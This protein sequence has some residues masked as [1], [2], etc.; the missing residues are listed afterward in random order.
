LYERKTDHSS[1]IIK[2]YDEL[3]AKGDH[4]EKSKPILFSL[5]LDRSKRATRSSP[6]V[7]LGL[8]LKV[9]ST[10]FK[11]IDGGWFNLDKRIANHVW[12]LNNLNL[13]LNP[14]AANDQDKV[15]Y[16]W[17]NDA[18]DDSRGKQAKMDDQGLYIPVSNKLGF[19]AKLRFTLESR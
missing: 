10:D 13:L 6:T 11:I 14:E 16:S 12:F 4:T 7:R 1:A 5:F 17:V 19:K 15:R 18:F 8:E 2:S 9:L 3:M